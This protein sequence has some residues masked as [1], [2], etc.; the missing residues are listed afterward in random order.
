MQDATALPSSED[1]E[2][3]SV[4]GQATAEITDGVNPKE[5]EENSESAE[6]AETADS[7]EASNEKPEEN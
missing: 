3:E 5:A 6:N 2:Q 7:S 1:I 4:E